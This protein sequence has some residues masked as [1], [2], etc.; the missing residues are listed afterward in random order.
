MNKEKYYKITYERKYTAWDFIP[1]FIGF[2][3]FCFLSAFSFK[4]VK[5]FS[6]I[7]NNFSELLP[8]YVIGFIAWLSIVI[9]A[10]VCLVFAGVGFSKLI[11]QEDEE[12]GEDHVDE[13]IY[14]SGKLKEIKEEILPEEVPRKLKY[15]VIYK[16]KK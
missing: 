7:L 4:Y 8:I 2:C 10:F 14:F 3:F 13:F 15:K 5:P 6:S 1:Q 9:I 12:E 16:T 11:L